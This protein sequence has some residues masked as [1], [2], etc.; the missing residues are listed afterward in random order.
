MSDILTNYTFDPKA[1]NP[2][3]IWSVKSPKGACHIWAVENP[4]NM[5]FYGE[6]YYGGIEIHSPTPMYGDAPPHHEKCW[7]LD[8]PCWHDGSS[9]QFSEQIE[10]ILRLEL[11]GEFSQSVHSYILEVCFRRYQDCFDRE[12]VYPS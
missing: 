11:N 1:K 9:L 10:P 7:L 4:P 12:A 3:H 6:L 8:A 2:R 5:P